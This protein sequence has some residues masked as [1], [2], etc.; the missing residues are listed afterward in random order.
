MAVKDRMDITLSQRKSI[1]KLANLRPFPGMPEEEDQSEPTRSAILFACP[2]LDGLPNQAM[3]MDGAQFKAL[4]IRLIA[5]IDSDTD[6]ASHVIN[7]AI[8][9][10]DWK[11]LAAGRKKQGQRS[12]K[13]GIRIVRS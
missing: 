8:R 13:V 7:L 12:L 1:P 6:A 2:E 4:L 3:P 9:E 10:D 11:K 5:E